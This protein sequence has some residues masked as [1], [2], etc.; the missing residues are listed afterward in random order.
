[1]GVTLDDMVFEHRNKAYGAYD[2]RTNYKKHLFR[3]TLIGVSIFTAGI[4]GVFAFNKMNGSEVERGI[5]VDLTVG[6]LKQDEP[7][8]E[9]PK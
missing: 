1:M 7:P 4:V 9:I 8:V 5:D 3:A 2:L 6:D